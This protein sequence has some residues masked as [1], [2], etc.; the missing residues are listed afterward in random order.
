MKNRIIKFRAWLIL[1][2][3]DDDGN[4]KNYYG[5]ATNISVHNGGSIGFSIDEGNR[6][7]SDDIFERAIENGNAYENEEWCNWDGQYELMQYTGLKDKNGRDIYE[8]DIVKQTMDKH[9]WIYLVHTDERENS[10]FGN[11]LFSWTIKDNFAENEEDPDHYS[12]KERTLDIPARGYVRSGKGC[13]VI[14]NIYENKELL[15]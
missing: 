1:D 9:W 15:K 13:E 14:G 4:D 2:D 11:Q 5:M 10:Q 6:I 12:Y 3:Y 8:G 7:F